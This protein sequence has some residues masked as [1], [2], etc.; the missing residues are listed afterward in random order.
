MNALNLQE[1]YRSYY[2]ASEQPELVDIP[3]ATYISI[4]GEGSPGTTAFYEK[5]KAITHF[6]EEL[7]KKYEGTDK[8]FKSTTVEIFYWYDE[9]QTGFVDIGNFYT[10]VDLNLLHYRIVIRIPEYIT[11]QVIQTVVQGLPAHSFAGNFER[12]TY[13]AGKCVQL[14]HLGPFAGEL[15]TLPVLQQFATKN[16]LRKSGMH[17]EIHL[18]NFESGQSQAHLKTILRDP[19]VKHI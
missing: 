2:T 14:L 5:K 12:F 4:L 3:I 17:H 18:T 16:G 19:V 11:A 13:T 10:T 9:E 15:E 1:I 6:A 8:A 7:Q